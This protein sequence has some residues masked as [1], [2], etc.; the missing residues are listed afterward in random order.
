MSKKCFGLRCHFKHHRLRENTAVKIYKN[1]TNVISKSKK[2]KNLMNYWLL[3]TVS[4]VGS[5]FNT[6]K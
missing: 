4:I 6:L 1:Y 2:K 5:E 3:V